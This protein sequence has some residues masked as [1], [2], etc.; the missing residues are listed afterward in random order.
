MEGNKVTKL[1]YKKR[2]EREIKGGGKRE[3][4]DECRARETERGKVREGGKVHEGGRERERW[5]ER[6]RERERE[7]DGEDGS[8]LRAVSHGS[9]GP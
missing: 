2:K 6:E 8:A 5:R 3:Q 4:V 1:L 9:C 7:R